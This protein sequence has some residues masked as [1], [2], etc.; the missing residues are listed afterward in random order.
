MGRQYTHI[1]SMRTEI[2]Q[3]IT[4]P[5]MRSIYITFVLLLS[6]YNGRCPLFSLPRPRKQIGSRHLGSV[7]SVGCEHQSFGG[8]ETHAAGEDIDRS[9]EDSSNGGYIPQNACTCT[10]TRRVHC[11]VMWIWCS[12][13]HFNLLQVLLLLLV[14]FYATHRTL[15]LPGTKQQ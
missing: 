9:H 4:Q 5:K 15:L 12:E 10:Y 14:G 7:S 1:T 2:S 8:V 13:R 6:I 11:H 3:K